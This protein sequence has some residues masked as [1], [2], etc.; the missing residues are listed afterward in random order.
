[1][2]VYIK[3][4]ADLLAGCDKNAI[5]CVE[6]GGGGR[7]LV[8][9][10]EG[11][12]FRYYV[13]T[14]RMEYTCKPKDLLFALD[15]T[16][17]MS[18]AARVL[19]TRLG[20]E[21]GATAPGWF[22]WCYPEGNFWSLGNAA[23]FCSTEGAWMKIRRVNGLAEVPCAVTPGISIERDPAEAMRLALDATETMEARR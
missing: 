11:A 16:D 5:E 3:A 14:L 15:T 7:A 1:M 13:P 10:Q 20:L 9:A 19:A 17:R 23:V 18:V 12:R 4:T 8:F 6:R 22:Y 2:T 21:C